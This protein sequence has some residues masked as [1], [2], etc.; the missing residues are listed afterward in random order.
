MQDTA[1]PLRQSVGEPYVW[2][3]G[4]GLALGLLMVIYLLGLIVAN[5][6]TAFW[7]KGI[8]VLHLRET[9]AARI[10]QSK[11]VAGEIVKQRQKLVRT[12]PSEPE[13]ASQSRSQAEWQLFLGNK[14]VYGV[15]F[16]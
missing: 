3:T 2:F 7:P 8:A 12:L 16:L 15:S 13:E 1:Q 14:D 11:A 6:F 5:G 4:M 9:S 10:Q